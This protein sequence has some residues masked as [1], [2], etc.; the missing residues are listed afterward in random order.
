[1]KKKNYSLITNKHTGES[2]IGEYV[3]SKL[4]RTNP[5]GSID[6]F[7]A[8]DGDIQCYY[9]GHA[10]SDYEVQDSISCQDVLEE[11]DRLHEHE[12]GIGLTD[13]QVNLIHLAFNVGKYVGQ[14]DKQ[15][16]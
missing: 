2:C 9:D 15:A 11:C 6:H 1:M 13:T 16:K 3:K 10:Y 12:T 14:R 7:D 5:S 4:S 8:L